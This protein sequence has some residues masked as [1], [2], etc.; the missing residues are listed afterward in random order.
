V[1]PAIEIVRNV[2]IQYLHAVGLWLLI[3]DVKMMIVTHV[4]IAVMKNVLFVGNI[5]A[6]GDAYDSDFSRGR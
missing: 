5:A 3:L 2:G 6:V 1:A 4:L